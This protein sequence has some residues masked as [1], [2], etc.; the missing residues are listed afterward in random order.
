MHGDDMILISVDDH[1]IEPPDR[2]AHAIDDAR[3]DNEFAGNGS[4]G[5]AL[6][7]ARRLSYVAHRGRVPPRFGIGPFGAQSIDDTCKHLKISHRADAVSFDGVA[8]LAIGVQV[9]YAADALLRVLGE[10]LENIVHACE[11]RATYAGGLQR[12]TRLF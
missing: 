8:A 5:E 6:I 3:L 9:V 1:I 11:F 12:D 10:L 2:A 7:V 4:G